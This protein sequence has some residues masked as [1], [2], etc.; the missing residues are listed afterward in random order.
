M[1]LATQ[2]RMATDA[3]LGA[4]LLNQGIYY[5]PLV[6]ATALVVAYEVRHGPWP[7][8]SRGPRCA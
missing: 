5:V 6:V 3:M 2:S 7:P 1:L 4:L 8:P